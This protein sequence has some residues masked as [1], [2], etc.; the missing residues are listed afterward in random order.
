MSEALAP[1]W[2]NIVESNSKGTYFGLA[3][4]NV[5]RD[6]GGYVD[7]NVIDL[8]DIAFINIVS[9]STDGTLSGYKQLQS[10]IPHNDGTWFFLHYNLIY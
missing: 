5:N 1:F 10:R 8:D 2:G 9:N 6:E 4:E 3:L 7:F